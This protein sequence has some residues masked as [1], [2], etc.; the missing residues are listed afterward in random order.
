MQCGWP[1]QAVSQIYDT[2]PMKVNI[3]YISY[4]LTV[5]NFNFTGQVEQHLL[6][7]L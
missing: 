6:K 1:V 4:A 3:T 2:Q 5:L 7:C